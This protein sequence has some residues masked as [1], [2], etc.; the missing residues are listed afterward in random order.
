MFS[1]FLGFRTEIITGIVWKELYS[2]PYSGQEGTTCETSAVAWPRGKFILKALEDIGSFCLAG[3]L[4]HKTG[5]SG[6][7]SL[8]LL[9]KSPHSTFWSFDF[10][11][12]KTDMNTLKVHDVQL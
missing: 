8:G 7:D 1:I 6:E 5:Q 11:Q 12:F 3:Y 10:F 9:P 2:Q 4:L